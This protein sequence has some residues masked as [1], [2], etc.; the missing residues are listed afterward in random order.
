R[1]VCISDTHNGHL[2]IP[3][4]PP[5]DILIHAGDL[6]N[7][8]N[9]PELRGALKW[10]S[11]APHPHKV[12][13]AGNH[14]AALAV[15]DKRDALLARYPNLIYLED[16]SVTLTVKGRD[17]TIYGSPRTRWPVTRGRR[18]VFQYTAEE[19]G[20]RWTIPPSVDI[21]VTHGPP[22]YHLDV[23]GFGCPQLRSHLW[24]VRPRLHV[25]GHIHQGRGVTRATWT[26]VQ[27]AYEL[28]SAGEDGW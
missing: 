20:N 2:N 17:L 25:F 1:V 18:G 5:G 21:L 7:S 10:L 3:P 4:L 15:P 22:Q 27:H 13:I 8:G 11:S 23:A 28:V 26:R 24:R 14:D 16:S 9:V 19:G 12:F 6:T